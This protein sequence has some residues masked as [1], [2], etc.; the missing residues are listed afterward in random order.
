MDA[1]DAFERA[2]LAF[3]DRMWADAV[4]HFRAADELRPLGAD[5]LDRAAQC[6]YL[7]GNDDE[8]I[9]LLERA[10]VE[11]VDDRPAAGQST[12]WLAYI[13]SS[14][15]DSARASGWL[16]RARRALDGEPPTDA[17]RS[18]RALLTVP[19]AIGTVL[20]GDPE[21]ALP[22]LTAAREVGV[23]CGHRDLIALSGVGV[24]QARILL[25]DARAGLAVLDETMVSVTTGEVS[26]IAT[27][28]LY[29]AVIIT[30]HETYQL[31]RAAEWTR[32]LGDWCD[33]QPD[34]VPF[35]GQCLVHRAEMLHLHGAWR[36][37][38]EQVRLACRRLS[39]PTANPAIG[40]AHYELAELHRLR[41]EFSAADAAYRRAALTGH[42]TQ[43]GLA[44]L[45]LAQGDLDS[46]R[47]G[48][49]R[50]LSE[51]TS[52]FRPRMLEAAVDM[53]LAEGDVVNARRFAEE[54]EAVASAVESTAL[55]AMSAHAFGAVLLAEGD[56]RPALD[57]LRTAWRLWQDL[58][59]PYAC[60]HVRV[61]QGRCC[62]ALGDHDT[63]LMEFESAA[64]AFRE[65]G[66]A[67]DLQLLRRYNPRPPTPAGLTA[68]EI[69][70]LRVVAAGSTN[71][72]IAEA[73]VLSEKTVARHLSNIFAKLGV[74][75]RSAATAYAYEHH[76]V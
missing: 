16:A 62:D 71:R 45:R 30:C 38:M 46:A 29:C 10:V 43:P 59:A 27:G 61:L 74:S 70:V 69:E 3:R 52:L 57:R 40:M 56:P 39:E 48:I 36:E 55:T 68:R 47:A 8:C 12:F 60:A 32:A 4:A 64:T 6:A 66:A 22:T 51:S 7:T 73:L 65:L 20:G 76:L 35:R 15:G 21:S 11:H 5:D 9:R 37:A 54:L 42:E 1:T 23:E 17:V 19:Q 33:A 2:H 28:I 31:R 18:V 49:G 50:A 58:D 24:G 14:S 25:G 63:A 41:G 44:R 34:L 26:P 67:P 75:S 53:A 72:E 13:L